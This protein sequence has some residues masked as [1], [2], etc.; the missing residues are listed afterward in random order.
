MSKNGSDYEKIKSKVLFEII[1]FIIH[2]SKRTNNKIV[3]RC[4]PSENKRFIK[5]LKK[6]IKYFF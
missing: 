3:I 1:K 4:H 5:K 6:N 2:T